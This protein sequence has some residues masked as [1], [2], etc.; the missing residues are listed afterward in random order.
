MNNSNLSF[1]FCKPK[2]YDSEETSEN[3]I[4][5]DENDE[6]QEY[7]DGNDA[8]SIEADTSPSR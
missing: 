6:I 5:G 8:G 4:I 7:T 2:M 1:K 3:L